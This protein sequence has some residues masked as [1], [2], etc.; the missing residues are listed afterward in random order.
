V[1]CSR[2]WMP[3]ISPAASPTGYERG[4][5]PSTPPMEAGEEEEEEAQAQ[6]LYRASNGMRSAAGV[7]LD[8]SQASDASA[9]YA[10]TT[11]IGPCGGGSELKWSRAAENLERE[12]G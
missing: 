8:A 5:G 1:T 4:T 2:A 11:W 9:M 12:N 6:S 7:L 10:P 3:A